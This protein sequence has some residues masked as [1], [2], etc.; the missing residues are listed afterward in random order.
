MTKLPYSSLLLFSSIEKICKLQI[1]NWRHRKLVQI[2]KQGIETGNELA[3][4]TFKP[5]FCFKWC[6]SIQRFVLDYK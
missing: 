2:P 6:I 1:G 5:I 4:T 3:H